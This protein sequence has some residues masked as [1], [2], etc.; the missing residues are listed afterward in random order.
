MFISFEGIDG[1]GKSTQA[2]LLVEY[3][4]TKNIK[5]IY[6]KEPGGTVIGDKLRNIILHDE[7]EKLTEM[8][9]IFAARNEH[10][11]KIILPTLKDK[12]W[13]IC[14]RFIDSTLCYQ[15]ILKSI[16]IET[17]LELH[18]K[19]ADNIFP[20]VTF[21]LDLPINAS[22][23]RLSSRQ[24]LN[25]YDNMSLSNHQIIK[26]GFLQIANKYPER[27]RVINAQQEE[28]LVHEQIMS[29]KIFSQF[30]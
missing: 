17:I 28:S 12:V 6:T 15:G 23:K 8:F 21:L 20:D 19:F 26:D 30:F 11:K 18:K 16:G 2:R 25:A 7:L 29:D 14:D 27:I 10:I 4:S 1:S 24:T 9:L 5:C 22:Q 3:L 13:I